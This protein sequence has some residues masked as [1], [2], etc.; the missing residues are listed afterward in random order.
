MIIERLKSAKLVPVI[1]L[2]DANDAV[3]LCEALAAGGLM[4]AEFTFRTSAAAESIRQVR[5][6]LPEFIVGAGTVTT[7]EE[8]ADAAKAGAQ[9]GVAPGCNPIILTA[10]EKIGLPFFPGVATPSDVERALQAG[11]KVLKF[12][13][14]SQVGGPEMIKTLAGVYGH[15]GVGFIPTGGVSE[16]NLANYLTAKGVIAVGG[17]WMVP[18]AALKARN[19]SRITEATRT[20]VEMVKR[21]MA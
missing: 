19:W 12:F 9:F 7:V 3:P 6:E 11:C 14:A 21:V 15:R 8:L 20:A 10:A 4:V 18:A 17:S 1:V 13:P 16:A 2:E 5:K